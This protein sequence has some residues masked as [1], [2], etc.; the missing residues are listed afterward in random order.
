M[1]KIF[2]SIVLS[3]SISFNVMVLAQQT[4]EDFRKEINTFLQELNGKYPAKDWIFRSTIPPYWELDSHKRLLKHGPEIIPVLCEY[5]NRNNYNLQQHGIAGVAGVALV[6]QT[7]TRCDDWP[8]NDPWNG[9]TFT[10]RW[11]GGCELAK[12]RFDIL[13]EKLIEARKNKDVEKASLIEKTLAGRGIYAL[14]FLME[15]YI[16][17]DIAM[18][19]IVRN[20]FKKEFENK[21]D[22]EILTWWKINQERYKLPQQD[23]QFFRYEPP[24]TVTGKKYNLDE[25]INILYKAWRERHVLMGE[26]PGPQNTSRK[27]IELAKLIGY[28]NTPSFHFLVDLGEEALP[29]LFLKLKEEKEQFTLPVIEKIMGKKLSPEEVKQHIE[30]AEKLL[31]KPELIAM[32]EWTTQDGKFSIEAKYISSQDKKVTLEKVNG[33]IITVEIPKLSTKDQD[34]IKRQLTAEK[35]SSKENN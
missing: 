2:I 20:M 14:T 24:Y 10:S 26:N 9:E 28:E 13:Y 27:K 12:E 8:E 29:Y 11:F 1:N 22:T 32:R 6:Y 17:G 23:K 3:I 21:N 35:E 25:K 34:Y 18:L 30:E 15:K 33:S 16:E 4:T 31:N 7:V 19:S 5:I